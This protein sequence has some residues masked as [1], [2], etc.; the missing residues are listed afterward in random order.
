MSAAPVGIASAGT[1]SGGP[2]DSAFVQLTKGYTPVSKV[3]PE[4]QAGKFLLENGHLYEGELRNRVPEGLGKI[5]DPHSILELEGMFVAGKLKGSGRLRTVGGNVYE[6]E[7]DD[8]FHGHGVYKWKDGSEYTGSFVK[9]KK[10]GAGSYRGPSGNTYVGSFTADEFDGFG[11]YTNANNGVVYEGYFKHGR[12]D[13]PG[14]LFSP[15]GRSRSGLWKDGKEI[16]GA[17]LTT[18]QIQDVTSLGQAAHDAHRSNSEDEGF[19][20]TSEEASSERQASKPSSREGEK[21]A[22]TPPPPPSGSGGR[23]A[24]M[25]DEEHTDSGDEGGVFVDREGS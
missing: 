14:K 16:K 24:D 19:S 25:A 20:P 7:F 22:T 23:E 8:L 21:A 13:G 9:G 4:P 1:H 6:G 12:K 18:E 17:K 3:G 11:I 10:E 2:S 15:D 5:N